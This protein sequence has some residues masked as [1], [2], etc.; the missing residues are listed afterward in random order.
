MVSVTATQQALNTS[1]FLGRDHG[2]R[3]DG[4]G[5]LSTWSLLFCGHLPPHH[6]SAVTPVQGSLGTAQHGRGRHTT[7][8]PAQVSFPFLKSLVPSWGRHLQG[9]R[10]LHELPAA[11]PASTTRVESRNP[12][13][14][15]VSAG[16]SW[17][18]GRPSSHLECV[19]SHCPFSGPAAHWR[20]KAAAV[21]ATHK[22]T[23]GV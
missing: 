2:S 19:P 1:Q 10:H 6:G 9:L 17:G 13:S 8:V 3:E 22:W 7:R 20:P 5:P 14:T 11:P 4:P 12:V 21:F 23:D 18:P 16:T 15:R